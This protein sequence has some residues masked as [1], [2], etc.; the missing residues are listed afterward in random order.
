MNKRIKTKWVKALRS[1]KYKKGVGQLAQTFY[2]KENMFHHE[3]FCCLGVLCDLY[4][5]EK[6]QERSW[7]EEYVG[8]PE[9]VQKWSGLYSYDPVVKFD[10]DKFNKNYELDDSKPHFISTPITTLSIL[11]D[12]VCTVRKKGFNMI[13]DVIEKQL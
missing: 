7:N 1:G 6:K 2:D 9:E 11:N 13:A 12:H 3:T 8:L 5:K 4:D 10:K